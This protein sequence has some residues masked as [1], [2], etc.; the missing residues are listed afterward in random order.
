M[1]LKNLLV[2]SSAFALLGT[3]PALA[4]TFVTFSTP[5]STYTSATTNYGG[6]DGSLGAIS[7]L[8]QFSFSNSLGENSVPTSWST[9]NN[10]PAVES[11]TPDVL[12][13][14][15]NSL[16]LTLSGNANTAGFE[17]EPDQIASQTATASFYDGATLIDTISLTFSGFDNAQLFALSDTTPGASISSIV[18]SDNDNDGFAIAQ[19][20]ANSVSATPEPSSLALLGTGL[21]GAVGVFRRRFA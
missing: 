4:D 10:P 20:R 17:F 12:Y 16:T 5:T 21:L 1:S 7:S 11:S 6:G 2:L 3:L 14:S 13:K 18:I 19:L 9:W 15:T 8:G